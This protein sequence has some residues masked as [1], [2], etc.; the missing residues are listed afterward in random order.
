MGLVKWYLETI[1]SHTWWYDRKQERLNRAVPIQHIETAEEHL[2]L[3]D[4]EWNAYSRDTAE[5]HLEAVAHHASQA[6]K[7]NPNASITL[8]DGFVATPRYYA[9]LALFAEA[10]LL[11]Q[12]CLVHRTPYP[13]MLPEVNVPKLEQALTAI[14]KAITYYPDEPK[15]WELKARILF[16]NPQRGLE[17]RRFLNDALR[18]FPGDVSLLTVR[19]TFA[20]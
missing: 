16:N 13:T 14:S 10:N 9:Y 8:P 15:G 7:K 5:F 1:G 19:D 6:L 4:R 17:A 3:A 2:L 12:T 11:L 20:R 18:R